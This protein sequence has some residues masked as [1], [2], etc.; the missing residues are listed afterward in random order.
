MAKKKAAA[1]IT[2]L[3]APAGATSKKAKAQYNPISMSLAELEPCE[4]IPTGIGPIDLYTCGGFPKGG[5]TL[6]TGKTNSGK[7]TVGV[8][9]MVGYLRLC[10]K[11]NAIYL[12]AENKIDKDWARKNGM[13]GMEE[14][15]TVFRP[16]STEEGQYI[17]R[18][19][20]EFR[21]DVGFIFVDSLAALCPEAEGEA[22]VGEEQM[23]LAAR[24]NNKW[25]RQLVSLQNKLVATGKD[26]TLVVINQ[27]RESMKMFGGTVLPGGNGQRYQ[28]GLWIRFLQ[29][30]HVMHPKLHIPMKILIRFVLEKNLGGASKWPG[31]FY[32]HVVPNGDW[33]V[34]DIEDHGFVWHWAAQQLGI[35]RPAGSKGFE[36]QGKFGKK[37]D[38][39]SQWRAQ[40]PLYS[41]VKKLLGKQF[42]DMLNSRT[43]IKEEPDAGEIQ[44]TQEVAVLGEVLGGLPNSP[45][46]PGL[47]ESAG[48]AS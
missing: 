2:V 14:R 35:L 38:F 4:R 25:F 13:S 5:T 24:A 16:E 32:L 37:E 33:K 36:F 27:E 23:G 42:D 11:M 19:A 17:V 15:V 30:E 41:L 44:Q 34:G 21:P 28:A 45:A 1:V 7:T 10:P 43:E 3:D 18:Q 29:S 12:N 8:K 22:D 40:G 39:L 9:G 31:E 47:G 20:M 48:D 26:C 6:L 46:H